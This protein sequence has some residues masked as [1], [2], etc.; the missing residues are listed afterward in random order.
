MVS[1]KRVLDH[2]FIAELRL[3]R[4]ITIGPDAALENVIELMVGRRIGCLPIC[5]NDNIV[6]IFSER[7]WL[8]RVL[9][10][11]LSLSVPVRQVMTPNPICFPHN[12]RI[13]DAA[14][15]MALRR[16]RHLPLIDENQRLVAVMSVRDVLRYL[17]ECFPEQFLALPPD[18]KVQTFQPESG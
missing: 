3:P 1:L 11:S 16:I 14:E 8:S 18:T 15:L 17:A 9:G 10:D 7:D 5:E 12:G 13:W 2:A 6:G 4:P